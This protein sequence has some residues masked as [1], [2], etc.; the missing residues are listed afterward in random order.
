MLADRFYSQIILIS[1]RHWKMKISE[2]K[3]GLYFPIFL[4]YIN[5]G[6]HCYLAMK[7]YLDISLKTIIRKTDFF[8]IWE[9]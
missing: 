9:N 5:F 3:P 1:Q 8:G 2:Y 7:F 4:A 6:L